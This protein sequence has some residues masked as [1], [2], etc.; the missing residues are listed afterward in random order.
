[1]TSDFFKLRHETSNV[2]RGCTLLPDSDIWIAQGNYVSH[3][4][5]IVCDFVLETK[6]QENDVRFLCE[7]LHKDSL[8]ELRDSLLPVLGYRQPPYNR[9]DG[10]KIF[11]MVVELPAGLERS[12][13]SHTLSTVSPPELQER[14]EICKNL[15][16][17]TQVVHSIQLVHKAIRPRSI[18]MLS[19]P[20]APL[21]TA[22]AYLQDW[23]YIR[24]IS[25]ATTE[26][27]EVLWSKRIYQHPERQGEY[28]DAVFETRHDIYSPGVCILEILLWKP[29]VVMEGG[30]QTE[31]LRVCELFERYGFARKEGDGG[32]PERYWGDSIRMTSRPPITMTIWQDI[33]SAELANADLVQLV[34]R[35]LQGDFNTV[36]NVVSHVG[37]LMTA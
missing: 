5:R 35:C 7:K 28:A 8:G 36:E 1:L 23:N 15:A 20:G 25:G 26:L 33:A 6:T 22:K 34:L 16:L 21:S 2:Q 32:L 17:A 24:E 14:L 37:R 18:L 3:G 13:L 31:R 29:F 19:E 12:S 4:Q 9:P 27:G 30:S 10:V 11:Q